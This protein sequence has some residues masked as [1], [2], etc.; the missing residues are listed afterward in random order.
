M[1]STN[2]DP[3]C[4]T[5]KD[6]VCIKCATRSYIDSVS[7]RCLQIDTNCKLWTDSGIC[8]H[9]YDGY[10]IFNQRECRLMYPEVGAV[11]LKSS[12]NS[13]VNC[14][15]SDTNGICTQC[16]WRSVLNQSSKKCMKVNDLCKTWSQITALCSGCYGGYSLSTNGE[17]KVSW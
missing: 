1:P 9:C 15:A 8:T 5:Y 3:N 2:Q 13:D 4:N 11:Q 12:L 16:I 6:Q 10:Y 7:K 17:C 14:R